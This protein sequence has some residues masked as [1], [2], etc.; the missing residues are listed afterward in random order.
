MVMPHKEET[1]ETSRTLRM[2]TAGA[3]VS[4]LAILFT[5]PAHALLLSD[6]GVDSS[7]P[8]ATV[9]GGSHGDA[10][11]QPT[12]TAAATSVPDWFERAALRESTTVA[13]SSSANDGFDTA[14]FAIGAALL[15]AIVLGAGAI[16]ATMRHRR[17]AMP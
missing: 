12:T 17:V 10:I 15:L 1:V 5:A 4:A 14:M 16:V 11:S 13:G 6:G 7:V 2:L 8:A 3:V 9:G